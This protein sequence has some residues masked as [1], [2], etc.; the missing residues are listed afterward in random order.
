MSAA[1]PIKHA[2]ISTGGT[3]AKNYDEFPDES[4][5]T[6]IVRENPASVLSIE[7]PDRTPEA[8]AAGLDFSASLPAAKERLDAL[9]AAGRFGARDEVAVV[10]RIS[11][12]DGRRSYGLFAMVDTSE[13]SSHADEPGSVIRNEEVFRSK[14]EQREQLNRYLGAQLSPVLLLQTDTD[15][16]R[17]LTTAA[18]RAGEPDL[19]EL[20]EAGR[21]HELWVVDDPELT[22]VA[23]EGRLVVADGNHRSLAAQVGELNRFLAVITTPESVRILPYH[24]LVTG[25][26]TSAEQLMVQ[27]A[28]IGAEVEEVDG[29]S[30]PQRHGEVIFY[31]SGRT[32]KVALPAAGDGVVARLDHTRVEKELFDGLLGWE[33]KDDRITYVGGDYSVEWLTEQ[34][35]SGEADLAIVIAPVSVDD[36]IDINL[37]RLVMP[38]KSTWFI[39]KARAGLVLADLE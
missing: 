33:A 22:Q 27:I 34:V 28:Q 11:D 7:M 37:N 24:R 23:G 3:S 21:R 6:D 26:P 18:E 9:R 36:F 31:G 20:D 19:S 8:S 2:W 16:H 17:A 1:H 29:P 12:T 32:W 14:V 10:Y 4:V 38:R 35:D 13:I 39:P 30:I 5:I 15:L 25:L